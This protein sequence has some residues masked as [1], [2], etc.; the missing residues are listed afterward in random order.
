M[1]QP[2]ILERTVNKVCG[3]SK[4]FVEEIVV[5][6]ND[7]NPRESCIARRRKGEVVDRSIPRFVSNDTRYQA[8][9]VKSPMPISRSNG[10][11]EDRTWTDSLKPKQKVD[12]IK[13]R[14]K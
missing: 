7:E 13:P 4:V 2:R 8:I 6:K 11:R 5:E 1:V 10:D 9:S 3:K 12:V 14:R